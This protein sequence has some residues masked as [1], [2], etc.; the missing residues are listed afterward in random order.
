MLYMANTTFVEK[1]R[2]IEN[3]SVFVQQGHECDAEF[4]FLVTG[5]DSICVLLIRSL[6]TKT[7]MHEEKGDYVLS[8]H[9]NVNA[10][11]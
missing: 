4:V 6:G 2:M 3:I 11:G 9:C 10:R 5:C 1:G 8:Q 7:N